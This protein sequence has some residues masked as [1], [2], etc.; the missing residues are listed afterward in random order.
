MARPTGAAR[1]GFVTM[2]GGIVMIL[3]ALLPFVRVTTSIPG[4]PAENF[5]GLDTDDGKVL[6]AIGIGVAV[7]GVVVLLT[8]GVIPKVMG[9]L[10][11]VAGGLVVLRGIVLLTSFGEEALR[12]VADAAAAEAP[13]VTADQLLQLFQQFGVTLHPGIGL[14]V[15]LAGGVI[16]AL[17]GVWAILT[18][19]AAAPPP[20][21]APGTGTGRGQPAEA[22]LSG[23]ENPPPSPPDHPAPGAAP[24]PPPPPPPVPGGP[25]EQPPRG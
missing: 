2:A 9:V 18:R 13:G 7:V 11:V 1:A 19:T 22:A 17:G 4:V 21:P 10:G 5:S 14:Y 25:P 16:A 23:F 3:G 8:R 20:P 15:G 6:V 12:E 24:P